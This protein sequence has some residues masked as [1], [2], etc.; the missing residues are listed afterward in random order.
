M[1]AAERSVTGARVRRFDADDLAAFSRVFGLPVSFWFESEHAQGD[2]HERVEE[3][4]Q[5]RLAEL[6]EEPA[7]E[8]AGGSNDGL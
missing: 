5:R 8:P 3:L 4:R 7:L 2:W 6:T 1:S